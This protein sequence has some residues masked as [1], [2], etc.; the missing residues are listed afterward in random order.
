[1]IHLLLF[2]LAQAQKPFS[3]VVTIQVSIVDAGNSLLDGY[4][5]S[6]GEHWKWKPSWYPTCGQVKG[7]MALATIDPDMGVS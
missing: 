3:T 4:R 7:E 5:L 1:M 2:N 6:D